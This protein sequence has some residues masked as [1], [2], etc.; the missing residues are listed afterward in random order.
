MKYFHEHC[1]AARL[2]RQLTA[3][4][5][6]QQVRQLGDVGGDAPGLVAGQQLARRAPPGFILAIDKGEYLPIVIA[7]DSFRSLQQM[8]KL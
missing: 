6:L 7:H 5:P 1:E 8:G 4:L 3:L 2:F